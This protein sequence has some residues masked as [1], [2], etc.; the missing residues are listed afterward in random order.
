VREDLHEPPVLVM[1]ARFDPEKRHETLVHAV[2]EL[3]DRGR[4][5]EVW[6]AGSGRL[7]ERVRELV[8]DL[9]LEDAVKLLGYVPNIQVR[10]W[11]DEHR[12][13][14][15]VLPSDGEGIPFSLIEALAYAVPAVAATAGGVEELLG[16]GCG[17][18]VPPGDV[19]ALAD[20]IGRLLDTPDTRVSN[21][22]NGRR[23]VEQE[24]NAA[25]AA[26][27][28]RELAGLETT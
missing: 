24:F 3:H 10:E 7:E 16:D 17:E 9:E 19:S 27:R 26:T 14:C 13:D 23:R 25:I 20:A 22:R 4:R 15:V 8:H 12:V 5:L 18:L 6:L 28:L 1:S 21:A 2:R 11:L